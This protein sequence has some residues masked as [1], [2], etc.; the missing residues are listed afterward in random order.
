MSGNMLRTPRKRTVTQACRSHLRDLAG[1]YAEIALGDVITHRREKW[2][3]HN[4]LR[5][6]TFPF[7]IE[8]NGRY[9]RD[10]CPPL[11]CEDPVC[12][13]WEAQLVLALVS[14][15]TI[16][17]DRIIPDRFVVNHVTNVSSYCEELRF[18][19]AESGGFGYKT[20]KPI[21][22][23]DADFHKLSKRTITLDR[24]KT[25]QRLAVAREMFEGLLPVELGRVSS[26]YSDGITNK[27][28]HLMGM[29]D[30]YLQMAMNP[31]AVHRLFT[32]LTDD[33][34]ALGQ[35]EEQQGLLTL[36]H[37]GNQ[38]YCSGS[39]CF[40][41]EIPGREIPQGQPVASTDRYGYLEAQ[42]A[43]GLSPE[44]FGEFLMP[45]FRKLA[46]RFKLLKFG[47]CEPVH[48]F[49]G[50]LQQLPGL[51]K[52]SVTP[53]CD[54]E[55]LATDCNEDVIWCRKPVPLKLCGDKFDP[56]DLRSHLQ[57][58]LDIGAAHFIE[59]VFRD[60]NCLTGAMRERVQTACD[61]VRDVTGHAEG[62]KEA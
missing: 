37:D 4:G 58:T 38:G 24:D 50:H 34:F 41:D 62:R 60:T 49:I 36:N 43:A 40:C 16:D 35:W 30:L 27:A 55:K 47:C 48:G 46:G 18:I 33:N 54:Q 17:D 19:R 56:A 1:R 44:M 10:L 15:E 52:V 42:E 53:W 45:H 25:E 14:Y 3:L 13:D 2:R 31:G 23:I 12:R 57:E 6:K 29:Q 28:V 61:I 21:Q 20:N 7:H 39:S 51:R 22:D 26:Y 5:A 8:D 32:F 11:T 9:L 59:F